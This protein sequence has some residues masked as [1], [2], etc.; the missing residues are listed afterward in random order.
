MWNTH[1]INN[2]GIFSTQQEHLYYKGRPHS[3][4]KLPGTNGLR[5]P[6]IYVAIKNFEQCPACQVNALKQYGLSRPFEGAI[7]NKN[8][9]GALFFK[10]VL[11]EI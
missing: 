10:R 1:Q 8:I 2:V 5:K 4:Q 11:H 7:K 6:F 9:L 3:S